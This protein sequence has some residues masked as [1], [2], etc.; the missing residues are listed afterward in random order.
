[1]SINKYIKRL[2]L[3]LI[4]FISIQGF[5]Q[6]SKTHYIPPL[7][8]AAF[9]NANPEDQYIYI[10][11]PSNSLVPYTIIPVGQPAANYI[12]GSVSSVNPQVEFIGN[13]NGQLFISSNSTSLVTN[14]KGY[15]IEAEAPIYISVRMN[16][17]GGAQA[18]A[19]V[20]KGSSALD[21]VFR[22]G[23]YTNENPQD[24]YLNF[25]SV[26]ATED[27]TQ[28]TFDNL[29]PGLIIKNY[30]GLTPIPITLN[31]GESYT[32]ATNSF[33][34]LTNRDGLIGCLVTSD[35]PIVVNCGSAN[36]SFHNGGGRDYGID[37]IA[38]LSKVGKEY[39]FVRGGGDNGWEN[40]LIV[41]HIYP[42]N[43]FVNGSTT[44]IT[45][46]AANRYALIEGN[47]YNA[48][49]NM[50]VRA[51]EDV[52]AYQGIGSTSE[53][54]QGMFFVPPLSCETRG[55]I[56]NIGN[57]DDIGSTTYSGGVSIVTKVGANV[58]INN[59][60]LTNFST[61]GPSSVD[62]KPDYVT[63]K[64]TGL[65]NNVSVQG[66]DELYV[67]YFNVN[68]AA[69]SGSFY[70]GFPS[71]PEI[72]FDAQFATLGNCI[73]NITLE[74]ANAQNFDSYEWYY[75]DGSGFQLL[76]AN[77]PSITPTVPARYKLIGIITCTGE[78]LE[79]VEVPVSICP[80]DT[81]NDGIIDNIDID[82]DNDGI[83]NCTESRGDVTLDLA[84]TRDPILRFQDGTANTTIATDNIT[85][86]IIDG[87]RLTGTGN[88]ISEIPADSNAENEYT[89]TFTEPVNIKFSE[90]DSYTHTS[91]EGE[92]FIVKVLPA[93]K[94]ITLVDPD[95][96]L[97]IDSNFDEIFESGIT[98]ISGSEIHFKY[99]QAPAGNT[100]FAFF[101]NQVDGFLFIHKVENTSNN[102]NFQANIS[103]TCFKND[104][105]NDGIEDELDLDS[106]ND[107]IPD[108]IENDGILV[109]LSGVDADNNGLDDVYDINAL[110]ID[111]DGDTVLDFYD[112]DSDNDGITDL[113]ETGQLGLLSDTDLNGI[114]DGPTYGVNGW[115]DAAETFPDSNLIG[116]ILNDFD[117]DTIFSYIDADSDGDG[118]SDVIE[119]GFSDGNTDDYLGDNIPTIDNNGLV[120]NTT[121]YTLPNS[122]YLDN[123]PI[124]ITTQP[125]NLEVCEGS[126]NNISLIATT[127]DTIQWEVSSDGTNWNTIV[128]DAVYS[129]SQTS[130]LLINDTP[131]ALE[132][133]F[134][135]AFLNRAGNACGL[136]SDI[137]Q[138]II[139]PLPTINSPVTLIQCDND[140]DG[141]S[142]FNLTEANDEISSNAINETFTYYLSN[143][144]AISGDVT[145]ADYISSPITYENNSSPFSDMVW[146]R[147]ENSFGCS[148][149][150]SI[151]LNVGISQIPTGTINEI[152][153]RCDD[154]LD[155][156]GN[157]NTNND[158]R[159]GIATFDFSY[160]ETIV[161]DYFLP[162]TPTV[163]FYRNEADALA[164][165]DAIINTSNYRNIGYPNMQQIYVRVDSQIGNDCQAFGPYITLNVEALPEFEAESPRIICSSDPTFNISLE[166]LEV[167]SSETFTYEWNFEGDVISTNAVLNNVSTPGTYSLTLT[168][169]D[170]TSCSRTRD[171][172][173]ESSEI[174]NITIED[175]TIVDISENNTV[176]I[177]TSNIGRGNYE[178]ALIEED[179][180]LMNYQTEP[181]FTNVRAGFYTLFVR[182]DIC[183]TVEIPLSVIG[184][185]KFFTP[186]GDG[187]N[188]FWQIQGIDE[189]TQ[190]NTIISIFDRYG[191]LIKQI[192]PTSRGW[193]GTF[194]GNRLPTDDYW[195]RVM[196]EDGREFKGH[197][198]LKR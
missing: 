84:D 14:D 133:N 85:E 66:D 7:T 184:S 137:I 156:N 63:Y 19:L 115:A 174:A 42:T 104:N 149:V 94:N 99:N 89:I 86:S 179:S 90:D 60:P 1:M 112:L 151:Q 118:C 11:T 103:L 57:I 158:D 109:A 31:E 73:P 46:T 39:I 111:T 108:F 197:F 159:D 26:M 36:G 43:I 48:S 76:V 119:A 116:Y 138:I 190:P 107:G 152:L 10:S 33:D 34:S 77:V 160:V 105:D 18:G 162:Q 54:N 178:F 27:G 155:I 132:D 189:N 6:L 93:N 62:G 143:S 173:V 49:G 198:T 101:A 44:P 80:D 141:I 148:S 167:N 70:S 25:V 140:I 81:D 58:T 5:S 194:N 180:N 17:G 181:V 196:L 69:T 127:F 47:S 55:N 52:F 191:K 79:S 150:S 142:F 2:F 32:I 176:T 38:G 165:N 3:I 28:V 120:N 95:D 97:L 59:L 114:E 100:P 41:P 68:G 92:Y 154:F 131:L 130:S 67:A 106:D 29:P 161:K 168:K 9:G 4:F 185:R 170:G 21:T 169:T 40:V 128:N 121:G 22:I 15:I 144:A 30:T 122:D 20:S 50:Y 96:R 113:I 56:D 24:N 186:N 117:T 187:I 163:T 23:S 139:N 74:A 71:N 195:F 146:A 171:I 83:L 175:I 61:I 136:Y 13:G 166:P 129:D 153:N 182:E 164:E 183:G 110:P 157:D 125:T 35:K 51:S 172:V 188:D 88:I 53:A 126:D 193:D 102:S 45:I 75:D 192:S 124:T 37:Q 16:A 65:V 8:N 123:A 64:V 87:I 147:V 78:T 12:T 91:V 82:N 135:R 177:D 145:S 134:Y 98:Q 72:N